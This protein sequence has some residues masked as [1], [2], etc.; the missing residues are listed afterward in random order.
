MMEGMR[1]Q[2]YK[3]DDRFYVVPAI[4]RGTLNNKDFECG[5]V[6]EL[7][8]DTGQISR[9]EYFEEPLGRFDNKYESVGW[10]EIGR[11][12]CWHIAPAAFGVAPTTEVYGGVMSK[13]FEEEGE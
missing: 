8:L 4:E 2:I 13:D 1:V 3:K 12:D 7:D 5:Y 9:S 11:L 10:G 6:Y